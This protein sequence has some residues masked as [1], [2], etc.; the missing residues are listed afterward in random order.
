MSLYDTVS[1][2]ISTVVSVIV[3]ALSHIAAWRYDRTE[4]PENIRSKQRE[5]MS[6]VAYGARML[7]VGAGTGNTLSAGVYEGS[8]GRLSQ[9]VMSEPDHAMR[10]RIKSKLPGHATAVPSDRLSI[11]HAA[12]PH[13]PFPDAS[14]D[15]VAIFFVLSHVEDRVASIREIARVLAPEGKL[16]ILDHG[17]QPPDSAHH[18]GHGCA[19]AHAHAPR[20]NS[21]HGH[22]APTGDFSRHGHRSH[23]LW[24]FEWL[25]FKRAH[26]HSHDNTRLEPLENDLARESHFE[27]AFSHR[28]QVD[29][30]FKEVMYGIFTR[31]AS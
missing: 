15:A 6:A 25:R 5:L 8:A 24:V 26:S 9:L 19:H 10:L 1:L 13:L 27:K 4:H 3:S 31:K 22:G 17:V 20:H 7:E 28:M 23:A 29:Y 12:L 16:L 21:A 11:I 2:V 30:F 14:F 18:H